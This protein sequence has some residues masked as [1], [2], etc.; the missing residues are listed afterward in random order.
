MVGGPV[1]E[2]GDVLDISDA[3]FEEESS[4]VQAVATIVPSGH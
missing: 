1:S 3:C 2:V 4:F